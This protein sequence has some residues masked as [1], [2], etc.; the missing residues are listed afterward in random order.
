MLSIIVPVYNVEEYLDDCMK[1]I[2]SQ[3][4]NDIEVILVDDGSTDNSGKMCDDY[5]KKYKEINVIHQ[6]NQGLSAARNSGIDIARGE[7]ITFIDSDDMIAPKF[8]HDA[9]E[10][11][12]DEHV[13]IVAFS[14]ERCE[15]D[16]HFLQEKFEFYENISVNVYDNPIDKMRAFLIGK[17]IGTMAWAKIYRRKIF[18]SIRYPVGKYHEDVFTTYKLVHKANK[19]ITTS[20][21]G[22]IYR[23][24]PNSI[25]TSNFSEKRLDSIEGK[26]QQLEFICKN[27]PTL[28]REAE[29]GVIYACNQCTMLMVNSG[30]W[31]KLVVTDIQKLYRQYGKSYLF[32]PVSAKGKVLTCF[33]M[34]NYRLAYNMFGLIKGGIL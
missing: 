34:I 1:S 33:A 5:A 9:I 6:N 20:Q 10:F 14:N 2:V 7:Y 8:I 26:R 16:F 21:I 17:E 3:F 25:T 18:D 23:K 11:L 19:I 32:S 30:Y 24:S 27:Y 15:S 28:R 4:T 29:C 31:N 13:D 12:Q 22:Y